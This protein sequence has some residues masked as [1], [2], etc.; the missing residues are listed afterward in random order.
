MGA[1]EEGFSVLEPSDSALASG[2]RALSSRHGWT[3]GPLRS[4]GHCRALSTEPRQ[5][6]F[7]R[8]D[9]PDGFQGEVFEAR[10]RVRVVGCVNSSWMFF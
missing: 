7:E 6:A 5:L 9:L 1:G 8:P 10:V 3:S 2:R 4:P